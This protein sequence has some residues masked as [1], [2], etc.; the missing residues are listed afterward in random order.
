MN[1]LEMIQ[2]VGLSVCMGNGSPSLMKICDL[3]CPGV[4]EDGLAKMF[5]QLG[6]DE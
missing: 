4:D 3:V 2:T 5:R 6:L 1:D